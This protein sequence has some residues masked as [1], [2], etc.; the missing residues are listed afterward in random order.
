[1]TTLNQ[2]ETFAATAQKIRGNG[3]RFPDQARRRINVGDTERVAS[4]ISGALLTALGLTHRTVPGL[5]AAGIGG[6]LLYRGAS[7]YCPAYGALGID[8]AHD[9]AEPEDYFERGIHVSQSYLVTKSPQELYTYWR[10]FE[11]LPKIMTHLESVRVIDDK[12]S[13]WIAKAPRI[14]GGTVEWD[15]EIIN[16]EPNSLIAWQSLA[17]ADVH[18]AGSVRFVPTDLGTMVSVV[19]DYLP[20]AGRVGKWVAQLFGEEPQQQIQEDLWNFKRIMERTHAR[21]P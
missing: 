5:I 9:D 4:L 20:P 16:D 12:R 18:N 3:A 19:I 21:T 11:N 7:G 10:N 2:P 17:G 6:T 13:H 8:S 15:A 14:A 1:M